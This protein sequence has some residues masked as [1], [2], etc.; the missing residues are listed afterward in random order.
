MPRICLVLAL[1]CAAG[2]ATSIRPPAD[3][4]DPVVVVLVDY[5]KHASL[6]LPAP[7][8]G[9]V[10]FAYG[11]WD[12]FARNKTDLC[13]GM[14][15]LCGVGQ[16]TLGRRLLDVRA[17]AAELRGRVWAEEL[18]ELKVAR[19]AAEA[20]RVKLEER[21][22]RRRET[23]TANPLNGLRFVKD[24]EPYVCFNNC[25]HVVLRW[26]EELGCRIFGCG[27]FAAFRVEPPRT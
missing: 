12:Y 27:W 7:P 13:T 26:L 11:E 5:G 21:Y 4:E 8:G 15:A 19:A 10:E 24:D 25:N 23:E 14:L 1:A 18:M 20:L 22:E 2:C 9:S 16:G 6:V 3:P 17:L